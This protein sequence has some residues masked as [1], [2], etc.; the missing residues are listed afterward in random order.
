MNLEPRF[1][2]SKQVA[3]ALTL[4]MAYNPSNNILRLFEV[5]PNYPLTTSEM[6]RDYY[7]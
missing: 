5:L 7:L 2:I 3:E 4:K 6:M 1:F